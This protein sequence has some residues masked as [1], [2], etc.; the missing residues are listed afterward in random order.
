MENYKQRPSKRFLSKINFEEID[1]RLSCGWH[2]E[3]D[4]IMQKKRYFKISK[5]L[6]YS[7]YDEKIV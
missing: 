6:D 4:S 1:H 2:V 5:E 7:I 3:V